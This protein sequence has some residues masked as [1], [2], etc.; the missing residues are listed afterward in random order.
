M[1]RG[2]YSC[3]S[4]ISSEEHEQ[5][6]TWLAAFGAKQSAS[7]HQSNRTQAPV[8]HKSEDKTV[9][10]ARLRAIFDP[11]TE[12]PLLKSWFQDNERPDSVQICQYTNQL[13]AAETRKRSLP[14]EEKSTR[15]WFKNARA[16]LSRLSYTNQ[17]EK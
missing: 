11:V 9:H 6:T 14:L 1:Y 16:K 3:L 8:L 7:S 12:I 13:N 4:S 17:K 2:R 10:L 5:F 15:I